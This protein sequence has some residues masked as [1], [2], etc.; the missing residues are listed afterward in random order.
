MPSREGR[1][2][3]SIEFLEPTDSTANKKKVKYE[4]YCGYRPK[5]RQE[6]QHKEKKYGCDNKEKEEANCFLPLVVMIVHTGSHP[7]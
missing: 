2:E 5:L 3:G 6:K 4:K 1:A 7:L